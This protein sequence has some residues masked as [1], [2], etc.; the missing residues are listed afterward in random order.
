MRM[1]CS[2]DE[3]KGGITQMLSFMKDFM[4]K[5]EKAKET[6]NKEAYEQNDDLLDDGNPLL[7]YVPGAGPPKDRHFNLGAYTRSSKKVTQALEEGETSQEGFVPPPQKEGTSRTVHIPANNSPKEDDYLDLQYGY[8]EAYNTI[9]SPQPKQS[10][11][12]VMD[13]PKDSNQIKALE[14]RFKV[15]EG[16]DAFDVDTL[17]MSLLSDLVIPHKF[18][19]PNFEK[20]KGLTCPRK[21]LRMYVRKMAAYD[22]DQKLMMHF[23]QDSLSGASVDWYMQLEKTNIRSWTDLA[24]TFL[25]QYKYNLDMAP[26]RLQLQNL[27]QKKDE[28]FKEY[29]QRWRE[30]AAR[31]QP[32]LLEKELVD[33]F[34]STL[35]G[36]YYK[37]M[38]GSVSSGFSDLVV[39]GERIENGIKNGKIQGTL[40]SPYSKKPSSSF[41]KKKE[42]ETNTVIHQDVRTP[43]TIPQ[44]K[45]RFPGPQRSFDPL[46]TSRSEIL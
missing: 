33:M 14:E 43:M 13:E 6:S 11:H 8:Q 28:A 35:Q 29:A 44:Q 18:K 45:N 7:G 24:N 22:H 1:V 23:F 25:K 39:I 2:V 37:R 10:S 20:Y 16:Y 32:P 40:S 3:I 4:E 31:V 30:I 41:S 26:N 17:E 38:V 34:M 36:P 5:Q 27:S 46:P 15:V 19:V 9:L 42:G 21:H 12:N